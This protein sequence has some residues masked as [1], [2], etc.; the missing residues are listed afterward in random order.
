VIHREIENA[1][2]IAVAQNHAFAEAAKT[3]ST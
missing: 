2:R 1:K 3:R